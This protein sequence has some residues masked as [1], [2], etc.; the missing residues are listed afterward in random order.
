LCLMPENALC[1]IS[2]SNTYSKVNRKITFFI[3]LDTYLTYFGL[4]T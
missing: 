4:F 1:G 2:M 3:L